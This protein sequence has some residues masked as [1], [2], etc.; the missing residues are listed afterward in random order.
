MGFGASGAAA[1]TAG[2]YT[3]FVFH[4]QGTTGQRVPVPLMARRVAAGTLAWL[5]IMIPGQDTG[6]V[7]FFHGLHEYLG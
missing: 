6:T 2:T 1:L 4:P 3:E 5:R 7:N